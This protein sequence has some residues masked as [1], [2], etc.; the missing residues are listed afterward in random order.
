ME[1]QII[2]VA[3]QLIK[4]GKKPTVAMVKAKLTQQVALPLLLKTL[5]KIES[6]TPEQIAELASE[7][8]PLQSDETT[9]DNELTTM[10]QQIIQLNQEVAQLKQQISNIEQSLRR[11]R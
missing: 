10:R 3:N 5:Q 11:A 6:M 1:D 4:K 7:G 9:D 8:L 2:A